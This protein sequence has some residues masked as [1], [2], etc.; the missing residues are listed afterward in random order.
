MT[1]NPVVCLYNAMAGAYILLGAMH[2]ILWLR[3]YRSLVNLTYTLITAGA[4]FH[5]YCELI[6]MTTRSPEEYLTCIRISHF[7]G[8]VVIVGSII[9]IR[10]YLGVGKAALAW[11]AI[12]IRFIAFLLNFL[13][14]DTGINYLAVESL[15]QVPF[16][17]TE[18][19]TPDVVETNPW[20]A[21]SQ[22]ALLF[23]LIFVVDASVRCWKRGGSEDRRK[24]ITVGGSMAVFIVLGSGYSVL[25]LH[26]VIDGPI[27]P[28]LPFILTTFAMGYELSRDTLRASRLSQ[29]LQTS[30]RRLALAASAARLALWE[31]RTDQDTIWATPSARQLFGAPPEESLKFSHFTATLHPDDRQ[32]VLDVILKS[33]TEHT[34]FT[35]E[36]RRISPGGGIRWI[37]GLGN[38]ELDPQSGS[39]LLRGVSVDITDQ[40]KAENALN[41]EREK[42]LHTTRLA[43]MSQM[44]SFLAHELNQ[45]LAA[46]VNNAGAA[47]SILEETAPEPRP[48]PLKSSTTSS[49]TPTAPAKSS[50][51]SAARSAR[52]TAIIPML[53]PTNSS[54]P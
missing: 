33:S 45:P 16:L 41:A 3:N 54:P 21:F 40:K 32:R 43:T 13:V 2:F 49:E 6:A 52:A 25:V 20:M 24:A 7:G 28:T 1:M 48:K 42:L 31:W 4:A 50:V 39:T 34:P 18:V 15:N 37:T 14:F 46:I 12:G 38:A 22:I 29:E 9:F 51:A 23:W 17:G 30:Q 10:L 53:I 26:R 5:L 11:T 47:L 8:T 44:A 27:L 35:A 36:Y 19:S